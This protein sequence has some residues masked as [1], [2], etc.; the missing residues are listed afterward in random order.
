M[1]PSLFLIYI[2]GLPNITFN[3]NHSNNTKT[4]L[5]ADVTSMTVNNPSLT[6]FEKDINL[7]FKNTNE[8]V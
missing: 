5:S 3:T 2:N 1:G 8:L 6:N 4:V 7:L